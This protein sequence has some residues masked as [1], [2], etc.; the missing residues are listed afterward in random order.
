MSLNNSQG[1]RVLGLTTQQ[2]T[3]TWPKDI[4]FCSQTNGL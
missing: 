3:I 1:E 4:D 2:S